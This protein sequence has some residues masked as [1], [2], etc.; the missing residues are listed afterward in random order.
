VLGY[1]AEAAI[2]LT[3]PCVLLLLNPLAAN[4]F[5]ELAARCRCAAS[6]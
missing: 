5:G 4:A 3:F 2:G 6:F 1:F